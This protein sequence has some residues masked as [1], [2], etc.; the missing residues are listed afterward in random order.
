[1]P[2]ER[3]DGLGVPGLSGEDLQWGHRGGDGLQDGLPDTVQHT[4]VIVVVGVG[5]LLLLLVVVVVVVLVVVI[6]LVVLVVSG[7]S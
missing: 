3:G 2:G 5:L 7:V 6:F 4:V 1:M